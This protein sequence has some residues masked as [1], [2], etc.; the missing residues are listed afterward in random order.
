MKKAIG[1]VVAV[2]LLLI[3]AVVSVVGFQQFLNF[4]QSD[5]Q[6]NVENTGSNIQ[7][8]IDN[9]VGTKLYFY[10]SQNEDVEYTKVSFGTRDCSLSGNLSYGMNEIDL[11]NCTYSYTNKDAE[12]TIF[13][14]QGILSKKIHKNNFYTGGY[15]TFAK[16][17]GGTGTEVVV[18]RGLLASDNFYYFEGYTSS[19]NSSGYDALIFKTDMTGEVIWNKTYGHS[20][21]SDYF[22]DILETSDNKI[23]VV[24]NYNGIST[25][26]KGDVFVTKIDLNGEILWNYTLNI[27][28][29]DV[30]LRVIE[31]SQNELIIIGTNNVTASGYADGDAYIVKMNLSGGIIWNKSYD[32]SSGKGD[33]LYHVEEISDGLYI[34][35]GYKNRTSNNDYE[36]LLIS[37]NDTGDLLWNKSYNFGTTQE[38]FSDFERINS[39][40]FIVAGYTLSESFYAIFNETGYLNKNITIEFGGVDKMV[41]IEKFD[42]NIFIG[43]G[44]AQPN[45]NYDVQIVF[46]NRNLEILS[47]YTYGGPSSE[48]NYF[49]KPI[50]NT[51]KSILLPTA[52]NSWGSGGY[53]IWLLKIDPSGNICQYNIT[54]ECG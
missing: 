41:A 34:A 14:T 40:S 1:P 10:N 50:I 15:V 31:N 20:P 52:T 21:D 39:S 26:P 29:T 49:T 30:F 46:L 48:L 24:G 53:D 22:W 17:F 51:D 33:A 13:T 4:Y 12:V 38:I 7:N 3:V 5:L 36:T 42:D 11:G 32:F 45:G 8:R 25:P 35:S 37:F 18:G 43:A 54:G 6:N 44:Y 23:V 2:S 16:L 28:G 47:N 19:F 9:V 27:S